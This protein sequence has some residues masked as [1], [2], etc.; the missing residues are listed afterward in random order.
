MRTCTITYCGVVS[1]EYAG[2]PTI[3]YKFGRIDALDG[4]NSPPDGRL[5]DADKGSSKKTSQHMRDVSGRM[6]FSDREMVCLI[7]AHTLG[8]CHIDRSGYWGPWNKAE[9]IFN[10]ALFKF[11]LDIK[12]TKKE[13]HNGKRWNGNMQYENPS[14][15]LMMLPSCMAMI[16]DKEMRNYVE[17]YAKDEVSFFSSILSSFL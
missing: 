5:P 9:N 13:T 1:A 7:G 14:G 6:G 10:N 12:W 17:M 3:P 8:R 15:E 4:E 2:G 16:Q 11:L